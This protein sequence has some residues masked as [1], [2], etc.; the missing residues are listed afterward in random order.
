MPNWGRT[1]A[2][3]TRRC[4]TAS[5]RH[6]PTCGMLLYC[7]LT[8]SIS[9]SRSLFHSCYFSLFIA[10]SLSPPLSY[11]CPYTSMLMWLRGSAFGAY[12]PRCRHVAL[13][14]PGR[15]QHREFWFES[16]IRAQHGPT[17]WGMRSRHV[18]RT[19]VMIRAS[20]DGGDCRFAS[21][22]QARQTVTRP[23]HYTICGALGML[24]PVHI[25]WRAQ[26][27]ACASEAQD[28]VILK[29]ALPRASD[30][31]LGAAEVMKPRNGRCRASHTACVI[32]SAR[33][34]VRE[35]LGASASQP[36]SG[37]RV[38][39][40]AR[41]RQIGQPRQGFPAARRTLVTATGGGRGLQDQR[42]TGPHMLKTG[43]GSSQGR[44][45]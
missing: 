32:A 27:P 30:V 10:L 11:A 31:P 25:C 8:L 42:Q 44:K 18:W 6:L 29:N 40:A 36:R 9:V 33:G 38:R 45:R 26:Q 17:Q 23:C 39:G 41:G 5:M 13:S 19:W 1:G 43:A 16:F 20:F 4:L 7:S 34:C 15:P 24:V 2:R 21:T 22:R 28:E 37:D 3:L 35:V 12:N 14:P